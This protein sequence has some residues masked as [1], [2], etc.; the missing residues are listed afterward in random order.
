VLELCYDHS[1]ATT[2]YWLAAVFVGNG[3]GKLKLARTLCGLVPK[4]TNG[5]VTVTV[6]PHHVIDFCLLLLRASVWHHCWSP[7]LFGTALLKMTLLFASFS[8]L[9]EL[10]GSSHDTLRGDLDSKVGFAVKKLG[11]LNFPSLLDFFE[12][13]FPHELIWTSLD[14]LKGFFGGGVCLGGITWEDFD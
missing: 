6:K 4:S 11:H 2:C 14:P 9:N 5:A 3:P 10:G 8:K 7:I 12:G 13:G 1:E